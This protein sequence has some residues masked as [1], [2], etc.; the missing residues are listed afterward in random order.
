MRCSRASPARAPLIYIEHQ[1]LSSRRV[2]VGAGRQ[3]LRREPDLEL[4]AVLNENADVT[5]YR[6]WQNARLEESGLAGASRASAC[7]R[8]GASR[9]TP[10][11]GPDAVE[12]GLR[13]QQGR[14]SWTT[15]GP[16]VEA[17]TSTACRFTRMATTSP[18]RGAPG[19]PQRPQLRRQRGRADGPLADRTRAA[20]PIC[21]CG[22]GP[23]TWRSP[24]GSLAERPAG[25]VAPAV[26]RA[27]GR[28]RRGARAGRAGVRTEMRGFVLPVQR[29]SRTP[30]RQLADLGVHVDPARTRRALRSWLA[31]GALQPELGTEH[32]FMT[33]RLTSSASPGMG[34]ASGGA[35]PLER[36][37]RDAFGAF[38]GDPRYPCLAAKTRLCG[39]AMSTCAC[40]ACSV[41][42]RLSDALA[43]GPRPGSPRRDV[44]WRRPLDRVRRRLHR[45]A[46]CER[47]RV[48]APA[49][50]PAAA[51]ARSRRSGRGLGSGRQRRPRRSA[52][53]VQLRRNRPLRRRAAP[54]ELPDRAPVPLAGA[55]LQSARAVRA[56]AP[57]RTVR[58]PA[59]PHPR[60]RRWRCRVSVNPNLADFGE[61]S[62]ARQYS[63]RDTTKERMALPVPFAQG[64][65]DRR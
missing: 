18:E 29:S 5:A 11:A 62:E 17:P 4:I 60:A 56:A 27:G 42:S 22:C 1:Y 13:P 34:M 20:S 43:D 49:L 25:R 19:I 23:S 39:P 33:T 8:C 24:A 51:S 10:G 14:A 32:V 21:A 64:V 28:Q 38:V 57:R 59:R 6:Q 15:S 7:S 2:V 58:S 46:A 35:T 63:G 31:G 50:D 26:A 47:A 54:G 12:S 9:Q 65:R 3:A 40:M 48:R 41:P 16:P 61:R 45:P 53:L 30:A 36:R 55:G 52:L 44:G 37:I